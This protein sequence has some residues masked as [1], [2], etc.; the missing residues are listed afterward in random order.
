MKDLERSTVINCYCF[1]LEDRI[2]LEKLVNVVAVLLYI[3]LKKSESLTQHVSYSTERD[4]QE[5]IV[6][7][8]LL[9]SAAG[10][11]ADQEYTTDS[12]YLVS[13]NLNI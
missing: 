4:E 6:E 2:Y 3:L 11:F 5:T 12:V 1:D 13:K 10:Y 8:S 7:E 9:K